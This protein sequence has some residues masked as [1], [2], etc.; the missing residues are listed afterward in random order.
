MK[1]QLAYTIAA[2]AF[3]PVSSVIA[4]CDVNLPYNE[5]VDCIVVEGSG[6]NYQERKVNFNKEYSDQQEDC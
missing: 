3:L 4:E 1:K 5:L 6:A 2:L